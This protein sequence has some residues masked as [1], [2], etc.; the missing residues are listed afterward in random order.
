MLALQERSYLAPSAGNKCGR[1]SDP[2]GLE[3]LA[4]LEDVQ[5]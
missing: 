2:R 5:Y 1:G 4:L 3:A